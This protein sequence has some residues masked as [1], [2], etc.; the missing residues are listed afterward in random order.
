MFRY[1]WIQ[2]VTNTPT[3]IYEHQSRSSGTCSAEGC[4]LG[5]AWCTRCGRAI[6]TMTTS[7]LQT[8]W[9]WRPLVQKNLAP[10]C[11]PVSPLGSL[12][13]IKSEYLGLGRV[14]LLRNNLGFYAEPQ[15]MID[16]HTCVM[17]LWQCTWPVYADSLRTFHSNYSCTTSYSVG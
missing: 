3:V 15:N 6:G 11:E 4:L 2:H 17:T 16:N 10:W 1:S 8:T 5:C 13:S 12:S 9:P 14:V 7:A